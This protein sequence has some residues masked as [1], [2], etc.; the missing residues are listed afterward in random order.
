MV[1]E[2]GSPITVRYV[3]PVDALPFLC[4]GLE[5]LFH[6]NRFAFKKMSAQMQVDFC[7]VKIRFIAELIINDTQHV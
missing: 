4:Q 6:E 3:N 2:P 5:M 1:P 7:K